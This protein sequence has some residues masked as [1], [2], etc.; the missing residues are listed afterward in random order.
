MSSAPGADRVKTC[1][2][3]ETGRTQGSR[4]GGGPGKCPD[5]DLKDTGELAKLD[6]V[7]GRQAVE[8]KKDKTF[9]TTKG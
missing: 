8:D 3:V 9:Q 6:L 2:H 1:R 5:R 4:L 7:E